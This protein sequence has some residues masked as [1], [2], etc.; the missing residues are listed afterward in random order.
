MS[1]LDLRPS[2]VFV[3][4][5]SGDGSVVRA[6]AARSGCA[7]VGV[8]ASADLVIASRRVPPV[9]GSGPVVFLH[10]L[11]GRRPLS[12]ATAVFAWL[13]PSALPLIDSMVSEALP[14]GGLRAVAVVGPVEGLRP[15]GSYREVGRVSSSRVPRG[16]LSAGPPAGGYSGVGRPGS[17]PSTEPLHVA[18]FETFSALGA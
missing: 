4:L 11:V 2:D 15:V 5:G 12:G 1:V 9:V 18:R 6:V 3:D 7:A 13:L 10:E 16:D 14:L 8:E 17:E